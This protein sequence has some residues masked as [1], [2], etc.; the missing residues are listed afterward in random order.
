MG[1]QGVMHIEVG[2]GVGLLDGG[3]LEHFI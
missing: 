2:G 1:V 3:V